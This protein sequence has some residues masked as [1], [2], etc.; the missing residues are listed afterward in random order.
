MSIAWVAL[1]LVPCCCR[2]H[3]GSFITS[4]EGQRDRRGGGGG[5]QS[6]ALLA[7]TRTLQ[8]GRGTKGVR[9]PRCLA[10]MCISGGSG[11]EVDLCIVELCTVYR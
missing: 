9:V 11:A 6:F 4:R 1:L 3:E 7:T 2:M 5:Q 10:L 8:P